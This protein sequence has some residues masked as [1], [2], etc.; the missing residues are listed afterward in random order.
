MDYGELREN[1]RLTLSLADEQLD[2][3][4]DTCLDEAQEFILFDV[5]LAS[6][7]KVAALEGMDNQ[8]PLS[9]GSRYRL[10][11]DME[12]LVDVAINGQ[13]IYRGSPV[14]NFEFY[15]SDDPQYSDIMYTTVEEDGIQVLKLVPNFYSGEVTLSYFSKV[16]KITEDNPE[17]A[18]LTAY[19]S[20]YR[21]AVCLKIAE[22]FH[23]TDQIRISS[24]LYF[25]AVANAKQREASRL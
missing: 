22:F 8:P 2:S 11:D 1:V 12:S 19:P 9:Q 20:V 7:F 5:K 18:I 6:Q 14:A 10:P 21:H 23:D 25:S 3:I 16:D 15:T 24:E 17:N 4:Y 13:L